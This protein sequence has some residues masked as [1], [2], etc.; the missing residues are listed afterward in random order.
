MGYIGASTLLIANLIVI[1]NAAWSGIADTAQAARIAFLMVA[2]W[3]VGFAQITFRYL[4]ENIFNKR[5]EGDYLSRGYRELAKI[6]NRVKTYPEL[7]TF[8][9]AFFFYIMG[10]Q[11][12]MFMAASFAEKEVGMST[13][14]LIVT[15]LVLE[16]LG[17]VGAFLFARLS[18]SYG[19]YPALMM[20][21]AVWIVICIGA[22]F[23]NTAAHFYVA[24]FFIGIVMGGIQ[25]L[26]RSTYSKILPKTEN[27]AGY[28]SFYDVCEK[29][30]MMCGLV[31]FGGLDN[32]TGSMRNAI[33]ALIVFFTLGLIF[34]VRVHG[35]GLGRVAEPG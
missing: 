16:Y 35:L 21:V 15:V 1:R 14:Q 19:N 25:S 12:V 13:E 28:F 6:W 31:M 18:K 30:A 2:I 11:T 7:R 33:V 32:L 34:L 17:I 24:A 20:A 4:P 8:L 10:L 3:W 23:V 27:N 29:V 22:L 9:A 5:P 26:S